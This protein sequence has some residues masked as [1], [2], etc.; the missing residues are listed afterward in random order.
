MILEPPLLDVLAGQGVKFAMWGPLDMHR[1]T[2][3]GALDIELF[4]MALQVRTCTR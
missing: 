4:A 3:E 2:E 1:L